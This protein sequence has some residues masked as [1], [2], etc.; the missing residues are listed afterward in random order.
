M[1]KKTL[2]IIYLFIK[3]EKIT[4]V[5]KKKVLCFPIIN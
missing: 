4:H 2:L 3:N 1:I 5:I